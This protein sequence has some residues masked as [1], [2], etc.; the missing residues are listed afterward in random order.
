MLVEGCGVVAVDEAHA[1]GVSLYRRQ[2]E[3]VIDEFLHDLSLRASTSTLARVD[4]RL[5]WMADDLVPLE[6]GYGPTAP[7]NDNLCNDF[8]Q[9]SAASFAA[10]ATARGDRCDRVDGVVT[11]TDAG[12]PVPFF[13]RAILEQP[14]GDL[15]RLLGKVR[16]FYGR[17]GTTPFL[18][19]SAWPATKV[20]LLTARAR[21]AP[22][23]HH[24]VGYADDK[25]VASG[26][27]YVG[28]D[29]V[30][31]E[32]IATLPEVRGRG[33]GRAI[34]AAAIGVDPAKTTA[35]VA[36]DLGRPIYERLGFVA[37]L[38]TTYWLGSRSAP[39]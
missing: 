10:F 13:N 16:S 28:D 36:S 35:L 2:Q 22:R 24:F 32:A 31:I 15:E 9:G 21:T 1:V 25:P 34:T 8:V 30:R 20:T 17:N 19:D 5:H 38:R 26:T 37:I 23:W 39:A 6:T 12:L 7:P 27:A 11:M 33:F 18:F 29:L 4:T 3:A 14:V